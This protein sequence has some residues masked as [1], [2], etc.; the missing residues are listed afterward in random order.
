MECETGVVRVK[1]SILDGAIETIMLWLALLILLYSYIEA[2]RIKVRDD[3]LPVEGLP[4]AFDGFRIVHISDLHCSGFGPQEKR[5]CGL[6]RGI[7]GDLVVFT[8]DYK[9]RRATKERKIARAMEEIARCVKSRFGMLGVLGN[10]DSPLVVSVIERAGIEMLSGR[11]K[12]LTKGGGAIWV[13]GIDSLSLRRATRALIRVT[14]RVPEGS[15][16]VLLSHGPDVARLAEAL[17]YSL[18]FCGDTHG[19]QIRLPLIGAPVVKSEVS[20]RYCRGILKEGAATVCI[21]SGIGTCAF[22]LRLL[23]P[24]EVRIL[25]LMAESRVATSGGARTKKEEQ[26]SEKRGQE[27]SGVKRATAKEK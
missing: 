16:K 20:R 27:T 9:R 5:L 18:I 6:L 26:A 11:A 23:C 15:F 24:P 13:A 1:F 8:G 2:K 7:E 14:S 10:K 22:P 3:R 4:R 21:S 19:G 17:G 12:R 25:T